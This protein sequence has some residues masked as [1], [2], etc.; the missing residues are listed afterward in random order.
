VFYDMAVISF[1]NHV[2]ASGLCRMHV[3]SPSDRHDVMSWT[4]HCSTDTEI[5]FMDAR[6]SIN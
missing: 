6:A 5:R 4:V 2:T 1:C 3:C